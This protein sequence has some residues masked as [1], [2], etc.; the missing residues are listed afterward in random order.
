LP[1]DLINELNN[2][3]CSSLSFLLF[4]EPKVVDQM[5]I[6]QTNIASDIRK[7]G[8]AEPK[9]PIIKKKLTIVAAKNFP[10]PVMTNR[11]K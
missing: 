11:F 9:A 10:N 1:F 5:K 7:V 4:E 3:I 6:T 8:C 2:L